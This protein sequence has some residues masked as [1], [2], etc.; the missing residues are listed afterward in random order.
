MAAW[1][2]TFN[3]VSRA[4][5]L[6]TEGGLDDTDGEA[7]GA[8]VLG[9][10]EVVTTRGAAGVDAGRGARAGVDEREAL[11]ATN[12]YLARGKRYEK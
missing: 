3:T 8:A 9:V 2:G 5:A 12:D 4:L 7:A 6:I 1:R 11:V 10:S